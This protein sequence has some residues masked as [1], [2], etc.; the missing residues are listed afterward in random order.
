MNYFLI[1][2]KLQ[3]SQNIFLFYKLHNVGY[4]A[5]EF[6]NLIG[7]VGRGVLISLDTSAEVF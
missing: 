1:A 6:R 5:M 3:N 2:T 4:S 7:Q